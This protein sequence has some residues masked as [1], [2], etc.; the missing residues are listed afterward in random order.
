MIAT[1]QAVGLTIQTV[2]A[3][4]QGDDAVRVCLADGTVVRLDPHHPDFDVWMVY[5][6]SELRR[7]C[8]LGVVMG[9]SGWAIDIGAAHD[10]AV[11]SVAPFDRDPAYV[12]AT[13]WSYGRVCVLARGHPEFDRVHGM[14]TTAVG[15]LA[16]RF[17]VAVCSRDEATGAGPDEEGNT[18]LYARILD[19]RP[20]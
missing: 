4:W 14:L 20:M 11:R 5:V 10:T 3:V 13:F 7:T 18:P 6:T 17:W 15:D 8:P 2:A 19:V 12:E 16:A 1:A 9:P